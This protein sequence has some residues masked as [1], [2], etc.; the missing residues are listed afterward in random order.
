MKDTACDWPNMK[1]DLI[2]LSEW[3]IKG[4]MNVKISHL[5]IKAQFETIL[6]FTFNNIE[7]KIKVLKY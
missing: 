5:A 3:I 4:S 2:T 7:V 6:P 1:K